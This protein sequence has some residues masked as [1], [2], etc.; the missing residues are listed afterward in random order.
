MHAGTGRTAETDMLAT[1]TYVGALTLP[2]ESVANKAT[3]YG[4]LGSSPLIETPL[5]EVVPAAWPAD[6]LAGGVMPA[7][8]RTSTWSVPGGELHVRSTPP[9]CVCT[10]VDE[11][12]AGAPGIVH[13]AAWPG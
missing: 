8:N 3:W 10:V 5:D 12:P 1:L 13:T 7:V 4:V 9:E 2:T 6:A 11:T